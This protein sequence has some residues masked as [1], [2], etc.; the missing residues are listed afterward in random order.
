M[1]IQLTVIQ[2]APQFWWASLEESSHSSGATVTLR[3][4]ESQKRNLIIE[5]QSRKLMLLRNWV[6]Y[7]G[8]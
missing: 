4:M 8:I 6:Q 5:E 7:R 2:L 3:G 1:D